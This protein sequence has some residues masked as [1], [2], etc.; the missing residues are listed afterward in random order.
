MTDRFVSRPQPGG[1]CNSRSAT[2]SIAVQPNLCQHPPRRLD[3]QFCGHQLVQVAI[4]GLHADTWRNCTVISTATTVNQPYNVSA[5]VQEQ[6]QLAAIPIFQYAIFY[7]LNME[8]DP[9]A[10]MNI[11]GP[12]Y[13]QWRNL[14]R[15]I[16]RSSYNSSVKRGRNGVTPIWRIPYASAKPAA[17]NP[18]FLTNYPPVSGAGHSGLAHRPDE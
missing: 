6:F 2:R 7:D 12:V 8:M 10:A 16:G 3:H 1:R 4:A 11:T 18:P 13:L 5:T 15:V 17:A 9:G 14:D